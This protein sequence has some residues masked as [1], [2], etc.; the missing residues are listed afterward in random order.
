M[1]SVLNSLWVKRD[2]IHTGGR[3]SEMDAGSP[4]PCGWDF[5]RTNGMYRT[6]SYSFFIVPGGL[7]SFFTRVGPTLR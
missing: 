6:R 5:G 3:I 1:L 2:T 4:G 7:A